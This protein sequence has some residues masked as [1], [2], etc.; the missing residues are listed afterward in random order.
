MLTITLAETTQVPRPTSRIEFDRSG[1]G[2]GPSPQP[3]CALLSAFRARL[4]RCGKLLC[5]LA[6]RIGTPP[7]RFANQQNTGSPLPRIDPDQSARL[8]KRALAR[9]GSGAGQVLTIRHIFAKM[10]N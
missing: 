2:P 1:D 7:D 3:R 9:R 8:S 5:R 4:Q 10:T 6:E